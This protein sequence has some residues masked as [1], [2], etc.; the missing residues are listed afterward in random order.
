MEIN[1]GKWKRA[2]TDWMRDA[3]RGV[4]THHLPDLPSAKK[5]AAMAALSVACLCSS[6]LAD[7]GKILI[8]KDTRNGSFEQGIRN[9]GIQDDP[10]SHEIVQDKKLAKDGEFFF[11]ARL[12]GG[13]GRKT[14]RLWMDIPLPTPEDG[15][16]FALSL[17]LGDAS[18]HP[19]HGFA[20][21]FV[22][23]NDKRQFV[24]TGKI[25]GSP[26][27]PPLDEWV[28]WDSGP[29]Q[30][31]AEWNGGSLQLRLSFYVDNGREDITYEAF[32]DN[33]RLV[34]TGGKTPAASGKVEGK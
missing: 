8:D 11:H 7:D 32:L 29:V 33:I 24:G 25:A 10:P 26:P 12:N 4:M 31:P 20:M 16:S 9:W 27:K 5:L 13:K 23:M 17:D 6:T 30:A 3:S 1:P 21:E 14:E 18:E 15:K 2:N 22:F 34:Q 19:L 28:H